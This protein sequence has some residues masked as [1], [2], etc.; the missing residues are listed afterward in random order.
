MYFHFP[1]HLSFKVRYDDEEK[2]V[3][4]EPIEMTQEFRKF[5]LSSTWEQ[6]PLHR[7]PEA[8]TSASTS[9]TEPPS[10]AEQQKK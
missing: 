3:V 5:D 7:Q 8:I 6:F 10:P 1:T 2:R 4:C 9:Q